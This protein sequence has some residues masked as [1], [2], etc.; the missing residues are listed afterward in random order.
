MTL[1][2]QQTHRPEQ[3]RRPSGQQ[4]DLLS[5][6]KLPDREAFDAFVRSPSMTFR[7]MNGRMKLATDRVRARPAISPNL[8]MMIGMTAIGLGVWGTFFPKNVARTFGSTAS[9]GTVRALF[10]ARELW[11][12]FTLAGDPTKSGALWARVAGDIFDIAVLSSLN[13]PTNPKRRAAKAGL[14]FVLLVTAL[15]AATA[16][17]M[18]T[19]KRNCL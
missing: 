18:S 9:P 17:R 13:R 7:T 14:A 2:E 15:D 12:G 8:S 11:S 16:V 19:V 6:V 5:K 10:G 4:S 3:Q 1:A